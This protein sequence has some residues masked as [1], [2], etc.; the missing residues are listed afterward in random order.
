MSGS[1]DFPPRRG[2]RTTQPAG[3]LHRMAQSV[4]PSFRF[5]SCHVT[6][7]VPGDVR[8]ATLRRPLGARRSSSGPGPRDPRRHETRPTRSGSSRS[9]PAG[10]PPTAGRR[11][12]CGGKASPAQSAASMGTGTARHPAATCLR[13]ADGPAPAPGQRPARRTPVLPGPA[14]SRLPRRAAAHQ[15]PGRGA[16]RPVRAPPRRARPRRP[17]PPGQ[18][19]PVHDRPLR[20]A[21]QPH[22]RLRDEPD[23]LPASAVVHPRSDRQVAAQAGE[24]RP[25]PPVDPHAVAPRPLK[26]QPGAAHVAGREEDGAR[27]PL[28][29]C[30]ERR[31][32][33]QLRRLARPD[34]VPLPPRR[35]VRRGV[36]GV[37]PSLHQWR[38]QLLPV[39][40]GQVD[41]QRH[42]RHRLRQDRTAART[43][44]NRQAVPPAVE[45][46]ASHQAGGPGSSHRS[47]S[48]SRH[49]LASLVLA[50]QTAPWRSRRRGR[51]R[52]TGADAVRRTDR[53]HPIKFSSS[54][55]EAAPCENRA[56]HAEHGHAVPA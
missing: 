55:S 24:V 16:P 32:A 1:V 3:P 11:V 5:E 49:R 26:D 36:D 4:T 2:R 14:A 18:L 7:S 31:E 56:D 43:P 54:R 53:H 23:D 38:V 10:S 46:S 27:R 51:S 39:G 20:R 33:P 8:R 29:Q 34:L 19:R 41:R 15:V 42:L 40:V 48:R 30:T 44:E 22:H 12:R 17:P 45:A 6:D 13:S 50:G 28:G 25:V 9:T 47:C 35:P 37:G 52:A 21:E